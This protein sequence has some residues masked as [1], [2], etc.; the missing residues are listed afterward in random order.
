MDQITFFC[1]DQIILRS[2]LWRTF[3]HQFKKIQSSFVLFWFCHVT[4][5][6]KDI[7]FWIFCLRRIWNIYSFIKDDDDDGD[8]G[9]GWIF[10]VFFALV[11]RTLDVRTEMWR[12]T[13]RL[14]KQAPTT[15]NPSALCETEE[16]DIE[17]R[18]HARRHTHRSTL[19]GTGTLESHF[20]WW[21]E[22]DQSVYPKTHAFF[23][24][25]S[26]QVG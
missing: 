21:N 24:F 20:P 26:L 23:S 13:T 25:P 1:V 8:F 6:F 22:G 3:R 14:L 5:V 12:E 17:P 11:V 10:L 15:W 16:S 2:F 9:L 4:V 7:I 18:P 19:S